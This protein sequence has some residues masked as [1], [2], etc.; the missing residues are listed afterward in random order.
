MGPGPFD[1]LAHLQA[2]TEQLRLEFIT[3]E[4]ETCRTFASLAATELQIGDREAAEHCI[5]ESKKACDTAI[6]FL[7][8]VTCSEERRRLEKRVRDLRETLDDVRQ[9]ITK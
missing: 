3:T 9:R 6:R 8:T 2:Q 7:S 1:N 4:L 5:T